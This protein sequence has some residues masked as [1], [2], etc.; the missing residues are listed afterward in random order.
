MTI[1]G[2]TLR[3][4]NTRVYDERTGLGALGRNA[5]NP[6]GAT[7]SAS[8]IPGS[9]GNDFPEQSDGDGTSRA[10]IFEV[11]LCFVPLIS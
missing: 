5:S 6:G 3:E 4:P 7:T 9:A 2:C 11:Q 8:A 10:Q 1:L